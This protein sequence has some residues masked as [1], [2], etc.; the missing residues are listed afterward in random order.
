[1]IK[2]KIYACM[3]LLL[4]VLGLV[5][6]G[7]QED[8]VEPVAQHPVHVHD[9][10][11]CDLCGMIIN[12]FPGPKGQL[13]TRGNNQ[14]LAFCST[15][16]M[17]AYALQPEHKHR[18]QSVFVH[19]VSTAEWGDMSQAKYIDAKQ[20]YFVI[21]H[22]QLGAMGPTLAAFADLGAAE[23]F[24]KDHGGEI[25]RFE[26]IDQSVLNGMNHMAMDHAH[27]AHH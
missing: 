9:G 1:M 7:G 10:Q 16:D 15:R 11:E 24:V 12:Q 19:D 27:A 18:V 8:T 20:A 4:S 22:N 3:I 17:F 23:Q 6:C 25:K 5:A 26:D 14:P 2:S 13:F 21:G